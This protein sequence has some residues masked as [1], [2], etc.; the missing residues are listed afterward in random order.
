M[1]EP[2]KKQ[3]HRK[4]NNS[5]NKRMKGSNVDK[6]VNQFLPSRMVDLKPAA[7]L[8]LKVKMALTGMPEK[9]QMVM[10]YMFLRTEQE[11]FTLK[12]NF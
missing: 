5:S 1:Q 2:H 9:M 8:L 10:T 7:N 3:K 6:V 11:Q 4:H 12:N